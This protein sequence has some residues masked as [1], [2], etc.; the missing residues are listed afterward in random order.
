MCKDGIFSPFKGYVQAAWENFL[1]QNS[2]NEKVCKRPNVA[3]WEEA[4]WAQVT[5]SDY[6]FYLWNTL[7][8]NYMADLQTKKSD[9]SHWQ[10]EIISKDQFQVLKWSSTTCLYV[11]N[12][13]LFNQ[14]CWTLFKEA[15][16][17]IHLLL[18]LD[19]IKK[20]KCYHNGLEI[21]VRLHRQASS[22]WRLYGHTYCIVSKNRQ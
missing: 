19:V 14:D 6:L 1:V 15:S 12:L 21:I 13:F 8:S 22:R 10:L 4:V 11:F 3:Q 2:E 16:F 9:T 17:R 5:L 7:F 18:N 20:L